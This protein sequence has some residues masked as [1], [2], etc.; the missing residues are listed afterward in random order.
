LLF[1]VK[2]TIDC[3]RIVTGPYIIVE[4]VVTVPLGQRN[5]RITD[6]LTATH[7][8]DIMWKYHPNFKLAP[9][10]QLVTGAKRVIA[11][12]KDAD[13][14]LENWNKFPVIDDE[15]PEKVYRL[16][17]VS[18]EGIEDVAD[19]TIIN[20]LLYENN[21]AG[22]YVSY[23]SEEFTGPLSFLT[24]WRNTRDGALGIEPG[25]TVMGRHYA[26]KNDLCLKLCK[27]ESRS[28]SVEIGFLT[29]REEVRKI[30]DK[31]TLILGGK[32]TAL[33]EIIFSGDKNFPFL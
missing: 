24:I 4:R 16:E 30:R 25:S 11:R 2:G 7:D 29:T 3:Q 31:I 27:G 8:T 22:I 5:F 28:L 32:K 17:C 14:D 26:E 10:A 6:T 12:D 23:N 19:G 15:L 9:G 18:A 13:H 33:P 20:A 1:E 21:N